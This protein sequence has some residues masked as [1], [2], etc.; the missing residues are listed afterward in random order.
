MSP[1]AACAASV[2][3]SEGLPCAGPPSAHR[4]SSHCHT[5]AGPSPPRPASSPP[6]LLVHPEDDGALG[7]A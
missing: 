3:S 5:V 2:A 1:S 7:A 6:V 4:P